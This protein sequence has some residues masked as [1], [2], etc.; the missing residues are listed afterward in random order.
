MIGET[1]GNYRIV[2]KLGEGAMG[3]VFRATDIRLQ[4]EVA[5]KFAKEQFTERFQREA[6]AVAA[7][8]HPNICTLYDVGPNYIIMELVDG[9]TVAERLERGRIPEN[10]ALRIARHIGDAIEAA[11]E[12]GIVHRDLKPSNIKLRDD[13]A[14][15]VLDFGLAKWT[16]P[17]TPT[18]DPNDSPTLV[19]QDRTVAGTILGTGAYMAP[20]QAR[21]L[22]VD[23]RADIWAFG[24]ILYEMLAG[25][26]PFEGASL[27]DTMAAVLTKE[28]E[29][30]AVP[31]RVRRLLKSCLEKDPKRRVHDIA[32]VW[33][34]EEP[35]E[36]SRKRPL[37]PAAIAVCSVV[38]AAAALW[39]TS[40]VASNDTAL[41]P[42]ARWNLNLEAIVKPD[43]TG[44]TAVLSPDEKRL[45]FVSQNANGT[46]ILATRLADESEVVPLSATEGA[47]APFFSPDGQ[48]VGFFANG[49]LKTTRISGGQP[50]ELC[51]AP[52]G[53]GGSWLDDG[54]IVA[55]LDTRVG[56]SRITP[57]GHVSRFTQL[58]VGE[59]THRWPRAIPGAILFTV[60][61]SPTQY[62][63]AD[64]AALSLKNPS[65]HQIVLPKAGISPDY[66]PT[67]HLAYVSN[68]TVYIVPFDLDHLKANGE[69][70][71]VLEGVWT[72]TNYGLAQFTVSGS[73]SLLYQQGPPGPSMLG[74]Y[75]LEWMGRDGSTKAL[76]PKIG[77]FVIPR[78]APDGT[79]RVAV[80]LGLGSNS[81]IWVY[82]WQS[83]AE[84]RLTV[85][86][87]PSTYPVWSRDG[88]Y[89]LYQA[90]DGVYWARSDGTQRG[91]LFKSENGPTPS[92]LTQ[93]SRI[94]AFFE[95]NPAGGAFI[96]TVEIDYSSGEPKAAVP[97]TL[98]AT[99]SSTPLPSFSRDGH[100]L[101]YSSADDGPYKVYVRAFPDTGR[102][103]P[104]APAGTLHPIWSR[105]RNELFVRT[106]ERKI[107]VI[108]YA[109]SGQ[110]FITQKPQIVSE[111]TF[112]ATG[113][114][115]NFDL[116]PE[117]DRFAVM[118]SK[119]QDGSAKGSH[120]TLVLNFFDEV[121][122]RTA[123]K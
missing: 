55:A 33:L 85:G 49:K 61:S 89:V 110:D 20:E 90:S 116:A 120:L 35:V 17:H 12:K 27:S 99:A 1:I 9:P 29:W 15:R 75:S 47:S 69:P 67:G 83:G 73:G 93:D 14:V 37:W 52:A 114:T 106:E 18:T 76:W 34:L 80:V 21:G 111:K 7:L 19:S 82:D 86:Q 119:E 26:R 118:I 13:G 57:G 81:D 100:W 59:V 45:V 109:T 84:T 87:G 70:I 10:E 39:M 112:G 88:K 66:L 77:P 123:G 115:P 51:D 78:L 97:E 3:E 68:G 101:A 79:S 5:I 16:S 2:S 48:R 54:T 103:W 96:K 91:I 74:M 40:R 105:T 30:D 41:R 24:V 38:I 43:V 56:L 72:N 11:H 23:K 94:L 8:N 22:T 25:R 71:P 46:A 107:L 32:D 64:I 62:A 44:P 63:D 102:K 60:S 121:K 31:P 42:V 113:L 4:R 122:R 98:F 104:V 36:H 53:R 108:P 117:G 6:R 65:K 50:T 95:K 92:S 28:P 58:E